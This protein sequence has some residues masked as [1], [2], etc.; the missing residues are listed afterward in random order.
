MPIFQGD[1]LVDVPMPSGQTLKL[2][3]SAV[4][5]SALQT[6]PDREQVAPGTN[7]DSVLASGGDPSAAQPMPFRTPAP[8]GADINSMLNAVPENIAQPMGINVDA[9]GVLQ[10]PT[11]TPAPMPQRELPTIS[12]ATAERQMRARANAEAAQAKKDKRAAAK[13]AAYNASPAGKQ[14]AV[15]NATQA[16]Y[17]QEGIDT[18]TAADTEAAGQDIIGQAYAERNA[19]LD[20]YYNDRAAAAQQDYDAEQAK[21]GEV[22]AMRKKIEN[23]KID[24]SADHPILAALGLALA[25]LGSAMKKQDTNPALD[26]FWKAIDRKV[27]AQMQDLELL[28]NQYNMSKDELQLFKDKSK[29]HLELYNTLIAGEADKAA[30]HVEA[31]GAQ[32]QGDQT[33]ARAKILA[34]QIRERGNAA[35]QDAV[36]WGLDYDQK[37]KQ[38]ADQMSLGWFNAKEGQRH[39]MSMEDITREGNYLDYQKALANI[40]ATGDQARYKAALE[41]QSENEKRG[42]GNATTGQ[43]LLTKQ[44]YDMMKQAEAYEAKAKEIESAGGSPFDVNGMINKATGQNAQLAQQYRDA[45]ATLRGQAKLEN[46]F[47][48]ND[49]VQAGKFSD[50]LAAGQRVT[51]LVDD[52]GNLFSAAGGGKKLL[53]TDANRAEVQA[54]STELAMALKNAWQL[55][56]LSKQDMNTLS[57]ATG[58]TDP[59]KVDASQIANWISGGLAGTDPKAFKSRL[60]ALSKDTQTGLVER[61]HTHQWDVTDPEQINNLFHRTTLPQE[62]PESKA[63]TALAKGQ[64]PV[65][66]ENAAAPTGAGKVRDEAFSGAANLATL[67]IPKALGFGARPQYEVNQEAAANSGSVTRPGLSNDQAAAYETLL[68]SYKQNPAVGDQLAA[69]VAQLAPTNPGTAI[70]LLGNMKTDMPQAYA[71]ARAMLPDGDVKSTTDMMDQQRLAVSEIPTSMLVPQ[72]MSAGKGPDGM[73]DKEGA[74]EL[75]RR[76]TSGKDPEAKRA[77]QQMI[78]APRAKQPT[79]AQTQQELFKKIT[80]GPMRPFGAK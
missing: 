77:L 31:I 24:H 34:D 72:V 75:V 53:L 70:A 10:P 16:G 66:A 8:A 78:A 73:R 3:R 47:R 76:A 41:A 28:K 42:I 37:A 2:P 4:P 40:R 59:E 33:R 48:I 18:T 32:L 22:T 58:G 61:L 79:Q 6:L 26:V 62:T 64:S 69:Q 63:L 13:Q 21:L 9:N 67:G 54:K 49:P 27:N 14:E 11:M 36:R 43:S 30:K 46:T 55:G 71:K 23:T 5:S 50:D 52:I 20:K 39:A 65:D 1:E 38:H 7:L 17:N 19:Q 56:V 60:D 29:N 45:A 12:G 74:A 80:A 35:A 25:G 68:K 57:Q 15:N 51:S 44:G